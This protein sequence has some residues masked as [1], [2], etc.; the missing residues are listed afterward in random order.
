M[1]S[2]IIT[3]KRIK[4]KC[5]VF[6]PESTVTYMLDLAGYKTKLYGKKVL[7]PSCGDGSFLLQ[8]VR[9]YI[10]D[11]LNNK[12]SKKKIKEGLSHDIYGFDI[13]KDCVRQCKQNLD[14]LVAHYMI[15]NVQWSIYC[16]D[17][18]FKEFKERFDFIFGNPPYIASPDLPLSIKNDIKSQFETCKQGKFDYSYAFV[19]K[20]YYQ[21][22]NQGVLA[23]LIP[24]SIFKKKYALQ[25]REL[26]KPELIMIH[27]YQ[28]GEVFNGVLIAP[29]IIQLQKGRQNSLLEYSFQDEI[30][31][32]NKCDLN[33]K[34]FFKKSPSKKRC[35]GDYFKVSN[36]VATLLNKAFL[37]RGGSFEGDFFIFDHIRIE[38]S[39]IKKAAS[40]K[41]QKYQRYSEYII[42]PYRYEEGKIHK[43]SE[44]EFET[45]YP[46]AAGYLNQFYEELLRRKA[47]IGA[48]WFE[49]GRSQALQ[50]VNQKK[51][52]I[53]SIISDCT[54]AYMLDKDEIPY[55]GLYI[56][57]TG[58]ISLDD[59]LMQLNSKRFKNY[60]KNVGITVNGT[61][62]RI[63]PKDIES[64]PFET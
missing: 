45:L 1:S 34:W 37:L 21:L 14:E 26:I 28:N 17:Y 42:F 54:Q 2:E 35:V 60:I 8:I 63:S 16:Q 22:A 11:C 9:R 20:S 36:S 31:A 25:L 29:A 64:F 15:F 62:K 19:E 59:L 40:P 13:D 43:Y 49:Y 33:Q 24:S 12:F 53:S 50:H 30:T 61:S 48:K 51:I 55:S 27:E 32:V 10:L 52:I 44:T 46:L 4:D 5:Q 7:E 18:L 38:K 3:N 47:D 39:I 6:T 56:I 58:E 23:L 41:N 57:P